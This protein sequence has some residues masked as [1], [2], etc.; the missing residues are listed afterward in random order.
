MQ[1]PEQKWAKGLQQQ[2]RGWS[3]GELPRACASC[4]RRG[5]GAGARGCRSCTDSPTSGFWLCCDAGF[6]IKG[7]RQSMTVYCTQAEAAV[8]YDL[9]AIWVGASCGRLAELA[10]KLRL[11]A[12]PT[13][14]HWAAARA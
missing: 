6:Q 5:A 14:S 11:A 8:V 4:A 2:G 12:L 10:F 13:P 9:A 1:Q 3:I 7:K